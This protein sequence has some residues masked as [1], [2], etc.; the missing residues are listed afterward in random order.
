MHINIYTL[1]CVHMNADSGMVSEWCHNGS[2]S[3]LILV[4]SQ[5][6]S[7][8]MDGHALG[9]SHDTDNPLPHL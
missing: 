6:I 1:A 8:M 4:A 3:E 9:K 2:L 5:T 7:P